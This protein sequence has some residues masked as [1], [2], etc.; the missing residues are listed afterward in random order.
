MNEDELARVTIDA[1][2]AVHRE[3]GPGL[4]ESAYAA[5]M[6]IEL[7]TRSIGF[8]REWPI[9][10]TYRGRPLGV[11]YRADFLVGGKLLVELKAVHSLEP[12]HGVQLLSYLRLADL[13]LGLLINFHA[14]LLKQGIQRVANGL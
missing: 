13:R 1:A 3:L 8:E 9:A 12:I 11:A 5:A 6:A 2:L 10:A 14:R 7:G 4:L